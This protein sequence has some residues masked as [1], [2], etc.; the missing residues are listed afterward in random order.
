MDN[1]LTTMQSIDT[2]LTETADTLV[3]LGAATN[4][5]A[6]LEADLLRWE[7]ELRGI[8]VENDDS[9][10]FKTEILSRLGGKTCDVPE[11]EDA[12]A[13]YDRTLSFLKRG[14]IRGLGPGSVMKILSSNS[15]IE[16][17]RSASRKLIRLTK[18]SS[19]VAAPPSSPVQALRK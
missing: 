10:A 16:L 8:E 19:R 13:G 18:A 5:E 9:D 17:T 14:S 11:K 12:C 4:I 15:T 6:D 2:I 1:S 3:S 7:K